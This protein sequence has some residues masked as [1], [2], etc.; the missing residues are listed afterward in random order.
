MRG[1]EGQWLSLDRPSPACSVTPAELAELLRHARGGDVL[2]VGSYYGATTRSLAELALHVVSVDHHRGDSGVGEHDTLS[3]YL[4]VIHPLRDRILTVLGDLYVALPLLRPSAFSL[5][6]YDA[7]HDAEATAFA[8]NEAWR[9]ARPDGVLC[10][11]DWERF[12]T[13]A[14]WEQSLL[15]APSYIVDSLAVWKP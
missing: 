4:R 2:E 7:A 10:C 11:H 15:P 13:C 1:P 9:V 5:V 8:L 3:E 14:G 6:F 12:E